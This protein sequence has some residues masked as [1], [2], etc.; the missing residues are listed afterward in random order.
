[1]RGN[2]GEGSACFCAASENSEVR[3][4]VWGPPADVGQVTS[5]HPK[6]AQRCQ[7]QLDQGPNKSARQTLICW[8]AGPLHLW[9][10]ARAQS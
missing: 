3:R 6:G 7:W 5:C 1:M 4:P 10:Q 9:S 2:V 8:A